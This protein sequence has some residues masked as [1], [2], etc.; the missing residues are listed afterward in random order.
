[1]ECSAWGRQAGEDRI[2]FGIWQ[3][4]FLERFRFTKI[5]G[6]E[7]FDT[8]NKLVV[9]LLL[10]HIYYTHTHTHTLGVKSVTFSF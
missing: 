7:T 2:T 10:L 4:A 8:L 5:V 3:D 6:I 9:L 1:M